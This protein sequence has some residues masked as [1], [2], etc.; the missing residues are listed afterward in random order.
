MTS[1]VN[2]VP[3]SNRVTPQMVIEFEFDMLRRLVK[4]LLVDNKNLRSGYYYEEYPKTVQ[5]VHG[6]LKEQAEYILERLDMTKDLMKEFVLDE[7]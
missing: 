6:P 3:I 7:K 5:Y 4:N 1:K 2:V